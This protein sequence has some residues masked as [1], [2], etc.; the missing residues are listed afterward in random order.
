MYRFSD[1]HEL[2]FTSADE[3]LP[4]LA[5][6]QMVLPHM[7]VRSHAVNGPGVA[8]PRQ[9]GFFNWV[10][11]RGRRY[12]VKSQTHNTMNAMVAIRAHNFTYTVCQL[13]QL[14][15]FPWEV[16]DMPLVRLAV[17]RALLP[18]LQSLPSVSHWRSV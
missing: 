11:V 8:V 7:T 10:I 16:P 3:Y 9:V 6:L 15:A 2:L 13:E 4:L 12:H 14:I 5:H 17:V 1:T 18:P